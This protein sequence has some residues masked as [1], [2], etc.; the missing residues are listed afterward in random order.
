MKK[1]RRKSYV[2]YDYENTYIDDVTKAEDNRIK[3]LLEAGEIKAIYAT[4]TIKSG[5]QFEV[6]IYPEFTRKEAEKTGVKKKSSKAQKNLNDK[7]ARKRLK[8]L[9]NSNFNN[10]D[11]WITFTYTSEHQPETVVA[12]QKDMKNYIRRVNYRRKKQGIKSAKYIYITEQGEKNKKIHHHLIMEKG[13]EADILESLWKKGRR[14]N[15]RRISEDKNGLT[16]LSNY[17]SKDP[18]GRKRWHSSNN[19]K[20]P[21]ESKSYSIFKYRKIKKMIE[22]QNS[23]QAELERTYNGRR[24]LNFEVR[25]N[26]YNGRFYIYAEMVDERS[27]GKP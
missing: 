19:L 17:L 1:E 11:Y 10:G 2:N 22:N 27:R 13:L 5:K 7:N 23:I 4:K 12:A 6:E 24:L 9:I 25:Y 20:K 18:K 14:N 21:K 16:G 26:K 3:E 15:I 8:R